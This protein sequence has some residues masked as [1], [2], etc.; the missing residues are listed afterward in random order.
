MCPTDSTPDPRDMMRA[1]DKQDIPTGRKS[2]DDH[3]KPDIS[4]RPSLPDRPQRMAAD[5]EDEEAD[6]VID[7][8]PGIADGALN[9]K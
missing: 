8:G 4:K 2:A 3:L 5:I 7:S 1:P 9:R 6:P